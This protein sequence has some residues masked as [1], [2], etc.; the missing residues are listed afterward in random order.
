MLT[1]AEKNRVY[2]DRQ[3][4]AK[5]A[6]Y[7]E[8]WKCPT[9]H[10]EKANYH[11]QLYCCDVHS[12]R[13]AFSYA[14]ALLATGSEDDRLRAVEVLRHAAQLQD[15]DPANATFGIW[16]WYM[17]EPLERMAPPDWNW[18]DFCGKE[19]LQ[20]LMFQGERLPED[21]VE[22]L[23][24]TVRCACL[25]IFRRNMH[26]GYTNIS[27]MGSYVTL[28][29]GQ[30]LGW[31]EMTEYGRSRFEK[32]WDYTMKNGTFAEYNSATYTTVAIEDLSR[33][34]AQIRDEDVHR[35]AGD[36]LDV[37]W[38]TVAEHFHAP[39]RQWTGPNARSYTWLTTDGTLSFLRNALDNGE[40]LI[41]DE[42]YQYNVDWAYIDM[43]CP[44]KYREAFTVCTPH[45][46]NIGFTTG[47]SIQAPRDSIAIA[48]LEQA[49]TLSSWEITTTWNQRRN[50]TGYWGGE[51]P[52]FI[53]A[54]ILHN[55]YDFSSGMFVT[56]QK[57]GNALVCASLVSD[58]G[59][60]HCNLDMIQDE[61]ITAYDLRVRVEL[62]GAI[63]RPPVVTPREATLEDGGVC[64]RISLLDARF[65]GQPVFLTLSNTQEDIAEQAKYADEHRRF[66]GSEPRYYVDVVFYHGEEKTF[67]L[68][69]IREAYAA[70][71][72]SM[73]GEKPAQA[74][75]EEKDGMIC[76]RANLG[77][78]ALAVSSPV[79]PVLRSLWRGDAEIDG[80]RM[81]KTYGLPEG[82]R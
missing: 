57:G 26:P 53:N 36:M 43:H 68:S 20:A 54:T 50:L 30:L 21:L 1:V 19:I 75:V 31:E 14:N 6:T 39:T 76:A 34:Y 33:I 7:S 10:L 45:D 66:V 62:G 74:R 42:A 56:A 46:V 82:K 18:A 78:A 16:S 79:R 70:L 77:G 55:L 65:D 38:R 12:T 25:S 44:D 35:M 24:K 63:E 5:N 58:G 32:A 11:T 27:I 67:R 23:K 3:L 9:G 29:A 81:K 73:E 47:M 60:T 41:S 2:F 22:Y 72:V 51:K 40:T 71:C 17:E 69:A 52:R 8:E 48:H 15:K 64:V 37:A 4:A 61:T 13:D 49:Y 28:C 59:D 80:E